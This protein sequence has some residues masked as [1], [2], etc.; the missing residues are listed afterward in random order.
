[1]L[2][3]LIPGVLVSFLLVLAVSPSFSYS[4][5]VLRKEPFRGASFKACCALGKAASN[6]TSPNECN[7]Y[8]KLTDKSGGCQFAY[9]ICCSQTRRTTACEKGKKHAYSGR[10]CL[11]LANDKF[12]DAEADCCNCCELGIKTR[13]NG[14]DC[15]LSPELNTECNAIFMDCCKYATSCKKQNLIIDAL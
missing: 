2:Q 13:K 15:T 11:E 4:Q 12:C 10:P 5:S 7:N 3:H 8:S 9:T 6:S 14:D 1:M